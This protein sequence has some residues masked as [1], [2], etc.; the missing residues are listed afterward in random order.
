MILFKACPRCRGDLQAR[1]DMY[2]DYNECLQCGYVRD[3]EKPRPEIDLQQLTGR[4][5]KATRAA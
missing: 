3:I 5:G 1:S 2:G 4:A